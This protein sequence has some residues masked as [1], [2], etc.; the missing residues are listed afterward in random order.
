MTTERSAPRCPPNGSSPVS[1]PPGYAERSLPRRPEPPLPPSIEPVRV[2]LP[3]T[4]P[5]VVTETFAL[6]FPP[7]PGAAGAGGRAGATVVLAHGAGSGPDSDVLLAVG[8]R[9]AAE[10]H[11]VW[12]FAFP[13]RAL[14]RRPPDPRPR[15]LSAWAD[16]VATARREGDPV[17]PLVLG[18]R[19]MGGRM[20]SLLVAEGQ[21]CAGLVLLGYPLRAASR[22]T[23]AG[24]APS[25]PRSAHWP[26]VA[27]PVLFVQGDR[28]P[29]CDLDELDRERRALP[30]GSDVAVVAGG[31]HSFAV[32]VREGRTR[33]QVLAEVAGTVASWVRTRTA[34]APP[35]PSHPP[36]PTPPEGA[37][38]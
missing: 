20:A 10:G 30:A 16:A 12:S 33:A 28:D 22:S 27:A 9:L 2:A 11:D 14:R 8:R 7:A 29:L 18:G 31:D 35:S 19:S 34:D 23:S 13:Y 5:Q 15:L 6:R 25:P 32:R 24:R 4:P 36:V 21:P 38:P 1:R 17:S 37:E 3:L 26:Q